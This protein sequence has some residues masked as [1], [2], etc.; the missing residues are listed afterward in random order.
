VSN[1][2]VPQH[3][4]SQRELD[5]LE[6]LTSGALAPTTAFNEPG[7]PV[8]LALPDVVLAAAAGS[9]EVELV[10][11][12]GL[13]LAR[14]TVSDSGGWPVTGLTHAQYGPFRRLY[15]SPEEVREAYAGRTFV[16]VTDAL[17]DE[18]LRE[19][20]GLGPVVLMALV[21]H[22]TPD[23][24]PV[25]L[26]RATLLVAT[27]LD[28]TVVAVP[29]A[30]HGDPQVDHDL[31]LRVVGNYAG[32]DPVHGL[33]EGGELPLE[34]TEIVASDQPPPDEQ[35]LVLFFTGLSGSGKS[36][37]ARALMDQLLER[38]VRTVTSLDGDV[39]RRNL[40]A[41]LTF[42]KE[43]RET[44]IRR[45]GWV[46][47]E[48]SRH[49][50][51]AVCSPI[52]PFDETRQQVRAMV[53]EA[54]GAFFL[55]H[56][57]TPLEECERRDRK[58]LYAKA[59]RGEI[60]EFTGIS[61]PYEEPEDA[62]VRVDTTGRSIEDALGDVIVAL[63]D[64][65]Y[66]DLLDDPLQDPIQDPSTVEVRGAPASLE[67]TAP[68]D[69]STSETDEDPPPPDDRLHVLFVCTANICRSPFMELTARDL[70]G[71][72]A[73][74]TFASAG[75]HGFREHPMDVV[76]G[77]AL[78][79]RGLGNEGFLSRPLDS[80]LIEEADLV[81]TAEATHRTF[82]LDDDPSV[83]RKVFTL[84]QFAEVVRVLSP[85]LAGRE[86]LQAAGMRRGGAASK[87]DVRDPYGR[88][89][90]AAEACAAQIDELLRVV[91]PA[92]TGA[93]RI[94]S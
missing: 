77:K 16:P 21:G 27:H 42:S 11:P 54:G 79:G 86:L 56:V 91:V 88:G 23:L 74:I 48:I 93:G 84:G 89:P 82:I 55:V 24:S 94:T 26:L 8:T 68:D 18:Q 65:G 83:F 3:C 66:V 17:T 81:L 31:G 59:R 39:V 53:D 19:V 38:G 41:G 30:S 69:L 34:L 13:P 63:R 7:S 4:P 35:G 90:E 12:E 67:T 52:A 43:D 76:M 20:N 47:A 32:P 85:D 33:Q 71:P 64:A 37:L 14:V 57:A 60:P 62:D 22:G 73:T 49:G 92:L 9:G 29:L 87:L 25:A 1:P 78:Q 45:I 15:L 61:S 51:V 50:G 80:P 58:G 70:A 6:L 40:S 75:T 2:V 72:D 10:D 36:T 5:D 46:A 28:A 44:N